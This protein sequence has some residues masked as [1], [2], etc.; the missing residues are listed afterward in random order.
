MHVPHLIMHTEQK[1]FKNY[2]LISYFSFLTLHNKFVTFSP[3]STWMSK[4]RVT[5]SKKAGNRVCKQA[6]VAEL[7]R[8]SHK[9]WI[10]RFLFTIRKRRRY[11]KQ[12]KRFGNNSLFF[13]DTPCTMMSDQTGDTVSHMSIRFPKGRHNRLILIT[14]LGGRAG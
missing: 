10:F 7:T 8:A 9:R 12:S 5:W 6:L 1:I 3:K 2:S 14:Q 13:V 11:K 4:L